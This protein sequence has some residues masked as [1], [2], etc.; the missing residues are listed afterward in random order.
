MHHQLDIGPSIPRWRN[1]PL[2]ALGWC[3][4]RAAGWRVQVRLPDAPRYMLI[5]APHTSNWDFVFGMAA[6][7]LIQVRVNFIGK[8]TLFRGPQG[9]LFRALGGRPVD[10]SAPGGVVQQTIDTFRRHERMIIALAPEG[11]RARREHWKRGFY[12]I[13]T[14]A[15]VPI[16]VA[17]LDYARREIG[18]G[19]IFMPTGDWATD[20]QPVFDFYRGITAK[21]PENFAVEAR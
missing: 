9:W 14:G 3:V 6:V 18:I 4:L 15:Q 16:A 11:T 17:Y 2:Y 10:R 12:H 8:H 20:M 21:R 1:R 7:L 19:P 5:L 13:A